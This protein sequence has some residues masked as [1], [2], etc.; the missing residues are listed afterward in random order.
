MLSVLER[1]PPNFRVALTAVLE[2]LLCGDES[3]DDGVLTELGGERALV[4]SRGTTRAPAHAASRLP[5]SR[6]P[7]AS[8]LRP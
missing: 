5:R 1:A 3:D 6:T 4:R 2:R 7:R 8:R